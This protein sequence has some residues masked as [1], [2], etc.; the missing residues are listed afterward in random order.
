MKCPNCKAEIPEKTTRSNHQN[1][2]YWG[3]VLPPIAEYTGFTIDEC[4]ELCKHLFNQKP[5]R[6]EF[7]DGSINT[8]KISQSTTALK[9]YEMENY[10]SQIRQWA[11]LEL[12]IYIGLP[13]ES[14]YYEETDKK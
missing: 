6:L 4:H 12:G 1:R 9:T 10:L 5:V 11:S 2:Y 3:A 13:N 7:K 8:L 14:G